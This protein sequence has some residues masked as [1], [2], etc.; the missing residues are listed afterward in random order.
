MQYE[1]EL[2]RD[3]LQLL[4]SHGLEVLSVDVEKGEI[5]VRIPPA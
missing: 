3:V 5:H 4:R 1:P 2:I